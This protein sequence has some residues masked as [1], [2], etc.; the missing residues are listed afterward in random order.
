MTAVKR[1]I[2][3][4]IHGVLAGVAGVCSVTVVGSF[5]DR[6]DLAGISDIDTVVVFDGSRPRVPTRCPR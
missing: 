6:E 4:A 5:V 3:E 2:A 1:G